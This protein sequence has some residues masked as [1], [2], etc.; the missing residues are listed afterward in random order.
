[1]NHAKIA[2]GSDADELPI[3]QVHFVKKKLFCTGDAEGLFTVYKFKKL[4]NIL[5]LICVHGNE[6]K[7]YAKNSLNFLWV[8]NSNRHD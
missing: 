5:S 1:M 8:L 3:N 6:K 2:L 4:V 7:I